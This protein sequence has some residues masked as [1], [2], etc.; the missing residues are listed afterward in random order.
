MKQMVLFFLTPFIVVGAW[1]QPQITGFAPQ[2]ASTGDT[3]TISGTNLGNVFAVSFGGTPA[4]T[5]TVVG[6]T[7]IKAVVGVGSSGNIRVSDPVAN[8]SMAGFIYTPFMKYV[9]QTGAGLKNGSS[10]ANAWNDSIF[11]ANLH[12]QPAG[13]EVWVAKGTYK[14]SYG[15]P[16]NIGAPPSYTFLIPNSVKLY[17]GFAGTEDSLSDRAYNLIHTANKTILSGLLNTLDYFWSDRTG[18]V[19]TMSPCERL[20]G[21]TVMDGCMGGVRIA[22]YCSANNP[23]TI[24]NCIIR[25]NGVCANDYAVGGIIVSSTGLNPV[26][27]SN[28]FI[29]DNR[30]TSSGGITCNEGKINLLNCVFTKNVGSVI[31]FFGPSSAIYFR[32]SSGRI[33]NCT[34]VGNNTNGSSALLASENATD[35]IYI[36]NSILWGNYE[37]YYGY[38]STPT[39]YHI[40]VVLGSNRFSIKNSLYQ[41]TPSSTAPVV[42]L[43]SFSAN[44]F[45]V[46]ESSPAGADNQWGTAD[47]GLNLTTC[48]PAINKGNNAIAGGV[49]Q[50]IAGNNRIFNS[51]VDLG[52]YEVQQNATTGIIAQAQPFNVT[53]NVGD[54]AQFGI[55]AIGGIIGYQWQK[56]VFDS[57]WVNLTNNAIY[58]GVTTALLSVNNVSS[59]NTGYKYR[60]LI[61][62]QYC[63]GYLSNEVILLVQSFIPVSLCPGGNSQLAATLM[64]PP[65]SIMTAQWQVDTGSTGFHYIT[66][67]PQ[68]SGTATANLQLNNIPSAWYGYKYRYVVNGNIYSRVYELKFANRWTGT[69]NN[70]WENPANWSCGQ[71]PDANTDVTIGTTTIGGSTSPSNITVGANSICRSLTVLPGG[72][73]VTVLPGFTLT[74]VR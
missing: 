68:Y 7:T 13:T 61:N 41:T 15:G 23:A 59:A 69:N 6:P 35:S 32:Y 56:F 50:D 62:N 8:N 19:V 42:L 36:N 2:T 22:N 73:T 44:P 72:N 46:N 57:G 43:N 26:N 70:S 18:Y 45:V 67:G 64:Y 31:N 4:K 5:F 33:T 29:V 54:T 39:S 48:S 14:P 10:W 49:L 52:A 63:S 71:V 58:S 65:P 20:D 37:L 28:S 17:G 53:V 55:S 47:D 51:Q 21:F 40:G 34:F 30:G 74:V 1:G 38:M 27:I 3:V 24:N 60:C 16:G 25:N 11:A 12:L 66:D 9:T